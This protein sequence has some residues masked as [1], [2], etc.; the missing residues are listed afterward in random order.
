LLF[1]AIG[2][3]T[4][5]F[6]VRNCVMAYSVWAKDHFGNLNLPVTAVVRI[7]FGIKEL[8]SSSMSKL[9][10]VIL[11]NVK[12]EIFLLIQISL[13]LT[14]IQFNMNLTLACAVDLVLVLHLK[15]LEFYGHC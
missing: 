15:V 13:T 10:Q 11:S 3:E 8:C 6:G 4:I 12:P 5:A 9:C 2:L 7:A 14:W 1:F